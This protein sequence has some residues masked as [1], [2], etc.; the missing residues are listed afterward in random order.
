LEERG[1]EIEHDGEV[2]SF[3]FSALKD[4]KPSE[5]KVSNIQMRCDEYERVFQ[6]SFP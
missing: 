5:G 1:Q 6:N 2:T 4:G 3:T